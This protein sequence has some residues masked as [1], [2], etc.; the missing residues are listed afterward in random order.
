MKNL[1]LGLGI[2]FFAHLACAAPASGSGPARDEV[3]LLGG[4]YKVQ[5]STSERVREAKS[6]GGPSRRDV[7]ELN[8]QGSDSKA[9]SGLR[10]EIVP[11]KQYARE[12]VR[13]YGLSFYIPSDWVETDQPI[14]LWQLHTSQKKAV[15]S[16][17]VSMVVRG[18]S[19]ILTLSSSDLDDG[20]DTKLSQDSNRVKKLRIGPLVKGEWSCFVA[21]VKWDPRPDAGAIS[22]WMNNDLLY[23]ATNQAM[24]YKTW[25]GNYP[26]IGMYAPSGRLGAASRTVYVDRVVVGGE[27]ADYREIYGKTI[28][29]GAK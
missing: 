19:M 5:S 27:N 20:D 26:K 18:K 24:G 14:V 4:T 15:L 11:V 22:V 9:S 10:T 2:C 23:E 28:C 12:G 21:K 1:I 7:I 25:L 3:N 13:W 6:P 17:P 16:P 29:G 8:L